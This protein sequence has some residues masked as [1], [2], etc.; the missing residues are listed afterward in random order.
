[1]KEELFEEL[2]ESVKQGDAILRGEMEPER[3]FEFDPPDV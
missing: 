3:S 1:M 2:L